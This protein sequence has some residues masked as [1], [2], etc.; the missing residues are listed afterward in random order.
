M[1]T[2]SATLRQQTADSVHQ[3]CILDGLMRQRLNA[4]SD[5]SG[6]RCPRDDL[7]LGEELD[8][9]RRIGFKSVHLAP[10]ESG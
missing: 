4:P 8:E 3:H 9:K 2:R 1:M 10:T 7:L 5:Q 6:I